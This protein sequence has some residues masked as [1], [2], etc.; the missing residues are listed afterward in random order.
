[1]N[2]RYVHA[3]ANALDLYYMLLLFNACRNRIDDGGSCPEI[4]PGIS[5]AFTSKEL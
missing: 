3:L 5:P 1:M 4:V 2:I